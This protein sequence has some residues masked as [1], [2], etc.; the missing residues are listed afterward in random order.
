MFLLNKRMLLTAEIENIELIIKK[1][2]VGTF[3]FTYKG[4]AIQKYQECA[5]TLKIC[6]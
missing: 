3:T 1:T 6:L 2:V 4:C 5:G